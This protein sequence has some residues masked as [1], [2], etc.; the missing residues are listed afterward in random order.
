MREMGGATFHEFVHAIWLNGREMDLAPLVA[1]VGLC[2]I[3]LVHRD[4][5]KFLAG[6]TRLKQPNPN[7]TH[8]IQVLC[9]RLWQLENLAGAM[10][11]F[12]AL[13]LWGLCLSQLHQHLPRSYPAYRSQPPRCFESLL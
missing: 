12:D 11:S 6:R 2:M 5:I 3:I 13:G 4:Q 10:I 7:P 1:L 8:G 9:K